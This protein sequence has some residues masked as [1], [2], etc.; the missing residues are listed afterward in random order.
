[1]TNGFRK[2]ARRF[3]AMMLASFGAFFLITGVAI[4]QQTERVREVGK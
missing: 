3:A 1:M 2:K 4:A